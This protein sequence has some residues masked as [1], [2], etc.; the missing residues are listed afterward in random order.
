[1]NEMKNQHNR[2]LRVVITGA[3]SSIGQ[4]LIKA[5]LENNVHVLGIVTPWADVDGLHPVKYHKCDLRDSMPQEVSAQ[6]DKA[7]ILVHLAWARPSNSFE[8][9]S[10]NIAMYTNLMT[11]LPKNI[12]T[13][14]MSTVCATS[15]SKSNYGQ[16]KYQLSQHMNEKKSVEIIAGL[17][18][19]EPAAGP[20]LALQNFV[21]KLHMRFKFAP[22]PLALMSTSDQVMKALLNSV[23][24][25]ETCARL[26]PAYEPQ[27]VRLVD[28]I[29]GILSKNHISNVPVP[30]PT[31][32]VLS[33]LFG[34]RKTMPGWA[35]SDRL[36]TLL[37]VSPS[38]IATRLQSDLR[39]P[40]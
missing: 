37:T 34:V 8:A 4:Q 19:S 12:K 11:G 27:P 1:M 14:Y 26:V 3:H 15:D 23:L 32:L 2:A 10:E 17:L 30:V 24:N 5:L 35:M 18:E 7:D 36:I 28:L 20:F 16:A 40:L 13:V 29:S 25:F 6:C 38:S 9:C 33:L 22:S 39:G 21:C 31:E